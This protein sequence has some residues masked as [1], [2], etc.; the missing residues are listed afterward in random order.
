M[1]IALLVW[2]LIG[3]ACAFGFV[4]KGL[5]SRAPISG[6]ITAVL[7][8]AIVGP[9]WLFWYF[10]SDAHRERKRAREKWDKVLD[11]YSRRQGKW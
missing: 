7:C 5:L 11:E 4:T 6:T 8:G 1:E 2:V 10:D 9:F 3:W